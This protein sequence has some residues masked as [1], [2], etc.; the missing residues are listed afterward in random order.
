MRNRI[1]ICAAVSA[2]I[3]VALLFLSV[4]SRNVDGFTGG[5]PLVRHFHIGVFD[6]GHWFHSHSLPY[7]GSTIAIS[8][9]GAPS[10]QVRGFDSPGIYYRFIRFPVD[11]EPLWTLRLSLAYPILLSLVFPLRWVL[12][13]RRRAHNKRP[14]LDAGTRLG[15]QF[16]PHRPGASEASR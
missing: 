7:R 16:R 10:P 4:A 2:L 15:L 3:P 12:E 11:P 13:F 1:A 9:P 14:A 5:S 8:G 6:G